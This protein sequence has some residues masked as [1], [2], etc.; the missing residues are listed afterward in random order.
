[1]DGLADQLDVL[2]GRVGLLCLGSPRKGDDAFGLCLGEQ[3]N[4]AGVADVLLAGT[5]PEK[6]L[7]SGAIRELDQVVLVDAVD[8][9]GE[10]GSV[11]WLDAAQIAVRFPQVSTHRLSLGLLAQWVQ[12]EAGIS[13]WL[14]GVQVQSLRGDHLS[15]PVAAT[16]QTLKD[17][18]MQRL[19]AGAP[20]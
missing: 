13:V 19:S 14:L 9:S 8:F 18:L 16:L 11:I 1:M 17:L 5:E 6:R 2:Q 12:R 3:L 4:A 20:A 15:P 7:L 10:P